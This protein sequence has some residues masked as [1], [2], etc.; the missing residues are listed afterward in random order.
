MSSSTN[1]DEHQQQNQVSLE[2]VVSGEETVVTVNVNN[3]LRKAVEDALQQTGNAGARPFTDWKVRYN[4][5]PI[6]DLDRK[7]EEYGFSSGNFIR[8]SLDS[9]TGGNLTLTNL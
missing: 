8:L 1:K 4:D 9:G 5:K 2:F 6:T 3:K 7:I